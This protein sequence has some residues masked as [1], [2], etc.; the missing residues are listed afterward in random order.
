MKWTKSGEVHNA[1]S[2]SGDGYHVMPI[3]GGYVLSLFPKKG[4]M[5]VLGTYADLKTA[6][7]MAGAFAKSK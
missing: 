7:R 4:S 1:K 2:T 3:V 5:R 6:K